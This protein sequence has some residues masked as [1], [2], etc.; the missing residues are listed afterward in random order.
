MILQY[1]VRY[2]LMLIKKFHRINKAVTIWKQYCNWVSTMISMQCLL[3]K[4]LTQDSEIG[5]LTEALRTHFSFN[6]LSRSHIHVNATTLEN[7]TKIE[8]ITSCLCT[9]SETVLKSLRIQFIQICSRYPLQSYVSDV[10]GWEISMPQSLVCIW[11]DKKKKQKKIP[12]IARNCQVR[13][14]RIVHWKIW[15]LVSIYIGC[16]VK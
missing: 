13:K 4:F 6:R 7:N 1:V 12:R 15:Q 14:H 2:V 10:Y 5:I 3:L 11:F 16:L 9:V 8:Q